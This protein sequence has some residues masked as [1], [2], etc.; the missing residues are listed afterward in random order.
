MAHRGL[1]IE[2]L[3]LDVVAYLAIDT[4][5]AASVALLD[6]NDVDDTAHTSATVA[7]EYTSEST[8]DHAEFV[9]E[10]LRQ[11]LG[12]RQVDAVVVGVGPGPF[13][14]LRAGIVTARTLGFAW[15]VPVVGV[16]SLDAIA[17][18]VVQQKQA[19]EEF[20]VATDAR[21]R[22]VYWARFTA[23]GALVHGPAVNTAAEVPTDAAIFGSGAGL[24][25]EEFGERSNSDFAQ[26]Q[27]TAGALGL[28]AAPQLR[29]FLDKAATELSA[30]DPRR[31]LAE[32]H[33]LA[34]GSLR[35]TTP[36]YLRESDAKVPGPRKTAL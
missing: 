15:D 36:L 10:H 28:A 33:A 11:L 6:W 13:T 14:G 24:Y 4:S 2:S 35:P 23:D 21:R 31:P 32:A 16:M 9:A 27:P 5:A 18:A 17:F 3:R 30:R 7:A 8:R 19:T 12:E 22:E 1:D 29:R 34:V 20:I 26:V 25:R